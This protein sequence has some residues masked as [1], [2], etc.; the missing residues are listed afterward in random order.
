MLA[1]AVKVQMLLLF[2][3]CFQVVVSAEEFIDESKDNEQ[4]GSHPGKLDVSLTPIC[5][6]GG[7]FVTEV[8]VT[9]L[10]SMQQ[11]TETAAVAK[12][13][14]SYERCNIN[15]GAAQPNTRIVRLCIFQGDR[16]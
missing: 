13:R 4:H 6:E 16:R 2:L 11:L 14:P 10:P 8:P 5:T 9:T 1:A 3:Q 7:S 15:I 12:K